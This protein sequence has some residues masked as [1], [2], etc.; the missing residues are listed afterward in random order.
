VNVTSTQTTTSGKTAIK[1]VDFF[2]S[3][4]FSSG[5]YDSCKDVKYGPAGYAMDL[6]GGGAKDY[7]GFLKFLGDEKVLGS[8]F[9]IDFP[10]EAPSPFTQLD[11]PPRNLQIPI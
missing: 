6:I 5:F 3:E 2:A 1:S 8:P 11:P 9:Q 7:H 10:A 4:R